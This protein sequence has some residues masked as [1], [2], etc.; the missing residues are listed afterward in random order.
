M[1]NLPGQEVLKGTITGRETQINLEN[2]PYGIYI[3]K[4]SNENSERF[5]RIIKETR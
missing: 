3:L 4:V 1:V 5:L 2:F